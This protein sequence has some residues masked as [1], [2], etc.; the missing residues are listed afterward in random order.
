MGLPAGTAGL[1]RHI[2]IIME[3]ASRTI[4]P[5]LVMQ[6]QTRRPPEYWDPGCRNLH[7]INCAVVLTVRRQRSVPVPNFAG[8]CG[9]EFGT[10]NR[11]VTAPGP[12][13]S[14][15]GWAGSKFGSIGRLKLNKAPY[16]R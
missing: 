3:F 6:W 8:L 4:S 14:T 13:L 1:K 11:K 16:I 9:A 10:L 12:A 5:V 15:N 2:S 7:A